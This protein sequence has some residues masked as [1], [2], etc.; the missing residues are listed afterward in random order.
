MFIRILLEFHCQKFFCK[1]KKNIVR[2]MIFVRPMILMEFEKK[3]FVRTTQ[4]QETRKKIISY[5]LGFSKVRSEHQKF[6][7][8][9]FILIVR[10]YYYFEQ[11]IPSTNRSNCCGL[12]A[13]LGQKW[14]IGATTKNIKLLS[15]KTLFSTF[16][17][18]FYL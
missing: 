8:R 17:P 14:P 3:C 7:V 10:S 13:K 4:F 11:E 12:R 15:D 16:L 1:E 9:I 2:P 18:E 6:C 5:V